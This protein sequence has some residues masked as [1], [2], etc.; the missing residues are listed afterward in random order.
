[1]TVLNATEARARLYSL[2]EQTNTTHQP[3]I[4]TGKRGNAVLISEQDWNAIEETLYLL[5]IPGMRESIVAGMK[6]SPDECSESPG[7]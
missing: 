1:M 3:V 5:S 4:I 6:E 7:W 2:I